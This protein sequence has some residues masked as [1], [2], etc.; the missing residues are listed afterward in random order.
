VLIVSSACNADLGLPTF[1]AALAATALVSMK[2]RQAPFAIVRH[3]AWSVLALVAGLFVLVAAVDQAGALV[4]TRDALQH[5][6]NLGPV[7]GSL[8][9]AFGVAVL[10]NLANNLPAGLLAGNAIHAGAPDVLR[11]ALL[12][13]VDLGPNLCV[14]GS[15]ATILWLAVLRREGE[16]VS[17]RQFF[18]L[19]IMV[20]PPALALSVLVALW[21][22]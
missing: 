5:A 14:S 9:A 6:A 3:V 2:D 1:L 19:G 10:C 22:S 13:G 7:A 8:S 17:F 12:I 20:M 15:L 18:R 11:N 4:L 21:V 16:S